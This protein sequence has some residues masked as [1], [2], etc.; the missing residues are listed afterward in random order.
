[1]HQFDS[2]LLKAIA[3]FSAWIF[4]NQV[5]ELVNQSLPNTLLGALSGPA[6]VAVFSIS[7][8]IRSVFYSLSITMSSVFIPLINQ[9]VAESDDNT[10]LTDLMARVGRYQAMLYCWVLGGFILLGRFF[11]DRWAGAEF[12][13]AYPLIVVMVIPL[14]IPLTQNTGIEIQRAKNKHRARS[15]AYLLMA[16]INVGL[17]VAL[18]KP[19]GYMAPAVG[20]VA[21]VLL[22]CGVFMNWYYQKRIRLSMGRF[23]RRVIPVLF[24][25][26]AVTACCM[27]GSI[28]LPVSSWTTFFAWGVVYSAI[29]VATIVK[30]IMSA[31]E[32]AMLFGKLHRLR[33]T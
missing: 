18:A 13:G 5:C 20:Y 10:I 9:I 28:F 29:Y 12:S 4:I 16:A 17:T 3:A 6:A 32:R 11:I 24:N 1:M 33:R 31:D 15:V 19:M 26:F 14:I 23:W 7:V 25:C 27:F 8:Q 2:A 22:G 21:Y 30:V